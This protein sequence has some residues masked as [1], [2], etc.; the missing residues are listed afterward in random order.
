MLEFYDQFKGL[1][2]SA[3]T[4]GEAYICSLILPILRAKSE[5]GTSNSEALSVYLAVCKRSLSDKDT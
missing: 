1:T 3:K 4:G 5:L 2:R